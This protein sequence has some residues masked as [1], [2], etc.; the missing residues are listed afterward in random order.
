MVGWRLEM[1]LHDDV[2]GG[3]HR[4]ASPI[5]E[6]C[7]MAHQLLYCDVVV[8]FVLDTVA[9]GGIIEDALR[10]KCLVAQTELLH[11]V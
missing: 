4:V 11:L 1:I 6:T 10:T 2:S 5:G 9:V 3:E 7:L 8:S